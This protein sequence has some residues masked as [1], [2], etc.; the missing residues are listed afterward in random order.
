M[1]T[2]SSFKAGFISILGRPNAGKSTLLNALLKEKLAIVSPKA[3]T[4]RHR[5][6]GILSEPTYQIIFSDTPGIITPEYTMHTRMMAQVSAS[7]KDA[8][9]VLFIIDVKDNAQQA[10]ALLTEL[11]L[12]QKVLIVLNK[13]DSV[14]AEELNNKLKT[15]QNLFDKYTIIQISALEKTGLDTLMKQVTDAMPVHPPYYDTDSISDRPMKFFVAELIREQ[16]FALLKE[17]LPY[18]STV[19]VEAY[20]EKTTLT[21][22]VASIIVSR[23]TQKGIILGEGGSMIKKIGSAARLQIEKFI[24]NKVFLELHVKVRANWREKENFLNEYGL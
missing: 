5:I 17:E 14:V 7:L 9:M 4:T 12:K 1:E 20:Q 19:L 8:D 23:E 13:I 22:I 2:N 3:Q 24:D 21:K 10:A 18:H 11:K 15:C 16:L 6:M